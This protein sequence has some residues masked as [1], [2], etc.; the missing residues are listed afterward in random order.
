M[1]DLLNEST[2]SFAAAAAELP[3]CR[4][5]RPVNPSTLGRWH[6]TGVRGPDGPRVYLEALKAGGTWI[7]S[8]EALTRFFAATTRRPAGREPAHA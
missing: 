3:H 5:D 1:S 7:T 8:R 4:S 6:L 2:L